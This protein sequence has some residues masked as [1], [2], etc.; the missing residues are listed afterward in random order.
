MKPDY[1][2]AAGVLNL[3]DDSDLRYGNYFYSYTTGYS[4]GLTWPLLV[5]YFGNKNFYNQYILHTS[6]PKPLRLAEQY[7]IRAEA[8][9]EGRGDYMRAG[10]DIATLRAARYTSYGNSV[11]MTAANAMTI[12]EQERI[13]ELYME[14]FRLM[15]LKRWH[16]GF[17]RTPQTESL[18]NGSSLKI[19]ADDPLFVWPIPQHELESPGSMILPNDSNK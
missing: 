16:K 15:D 1:V 3:Y 14:G 9:A 19:E 17:E 2:P 6:M 18:D 11:A 13:K 8:Y 10:E 12:I 5:K 4:H 7:L